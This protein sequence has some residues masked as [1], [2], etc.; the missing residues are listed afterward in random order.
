MKTK[1]LLLL[2]VFTASFTIIAC[3]KGANDPTLSCKS[4]TARLKGEWKL[5]GG[6][7]TST[8]GTNVTI[9]TYDGATVATTYN[10]SSAVSIV[11]TDLI[12]FDKNGTYTRSGA[13]DTVTFDEEGGWAWIGKCKEAKLKNK[14]AMGLSSTKYSD[15]NGSMEQDAGFYVAGIWILDELSSKKMVVI[16]EGSSTTGGVKTTRSGTY[17]Y[18]KI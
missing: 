2:L 9:E 6:E 8:T 5:T 3:K 1:T 7:I 13:R 16:I 4:R 14:E 11:Y 15:S 12:K 17:I 10:G 18:E